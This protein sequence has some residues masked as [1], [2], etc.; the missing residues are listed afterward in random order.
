MK[1]RIRPGVY[2]EEP[3]DCREHRHRRDGSDPKGTDVHQRR[4]FRRKRERGKH[5][6][7]VRAASD[8][9]QDSHAERGVRVSEPPHPRGSS[10][11]MQV[12]V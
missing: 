8:A 10:L 9:V 5:S 1:A 12:I 6:E 7:E 3:Y 11:H 2:A 4:A